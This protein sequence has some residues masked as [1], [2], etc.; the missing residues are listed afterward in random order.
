VTRSGDAGAG[1]R[2]P[3][4]WARRR[5]DSSKGSLVAQLLAADGFDTGYGDIAE[6]HWVDFLSDWATQLNI[7]PDS[8]VFEVG[9]GSGAF[10]YEMHRRGCDVAGLDQSAA[11]VDI[12]RA[13]MPD[14]HFEAADLPELPRADVVTSFS[15][16]GYFPSLAY[17]EAVVRR[18]VAKAKTG[19]AIFDLPDSA[20]RDDALAER[21]AP[22]GGPDNYAARYEGLAHLYYSREWIEQVLRSARLEGVRTADQDLPAY[23]NGQYRF[24]AWGF[25]AVADADR[26]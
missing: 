26:R 14:G 4:V 11:L 22:A 20:R 10:L 12:A 13:T 7:T 23:R 17:A 3:E 15:V 21:I 25:R 16:F 6:S 8:S 18:M 1:N 5:L 19:V 2:W 9:C 24:N